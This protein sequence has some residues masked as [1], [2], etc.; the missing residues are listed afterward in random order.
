VN[1]LKKLD[2]HFEESISVVFFSLM[3]IL[4]FSQIIM[5]YIFNYSIVWSEEL[6][7]YLF[8]WLIYLGASLG[9]K[10]DSHLKVDVVY[11]IVPKKLHKYIQL[12]SNIIFLGFT[13]VIFRQGIPLVYDMLFVRNQLTPALQIPMGA[14]Y[15]IIPFA[16][17]LM[18]LRLLQRIVKISR[19]FKDSLSE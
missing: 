7:R 19:N 17:L 12:F 18:S 9:I 14:I 4:I 6:A 2:D 16:A 10:N 13:L 5:R 8:V 3:I 1:I 11:M 15:T